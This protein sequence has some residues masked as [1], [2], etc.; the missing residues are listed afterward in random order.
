MSRLLGSM[1]L[2]AISILLYVPI[3]LIS[4][5]APE[6]RLASDFFSLRMISG[7]TWR[8]SI[9]GAFVGLSLLFF[10]GD[11][12]RSAGPSRRS[13]ANNMIEALIFIP[14]LVLFLL[15]RGFATTEFFLLG[16]MILLTFLAD[17]AILVLTS[18][19]S[20]AYESN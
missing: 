19:R 14:C 12:L 16:L 10:F 2:L 8:V 6:E 7:E 15:V 5:G 4:G 3:A 9:G 18:R 13:V 17:S 1:P 20:I 11:V